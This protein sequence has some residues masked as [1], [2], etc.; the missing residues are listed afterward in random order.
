M[1]C[2]QIEIAS[3]LGIS[4]DTL[5]RACNRERLTSF[6]DYFGQKRQIGFTRLRNKQ[7]ESALGGNVTMLI[8]LGKQFLGQ[9]DKV[10]STNNPYANAGT[11]TLDVP[12]EFRQAKSKGDKPN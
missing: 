5:E 10:E 6:A 2:T 1:Q 3:K 7:F 4:V 11:G 9:S 8:W 12:T